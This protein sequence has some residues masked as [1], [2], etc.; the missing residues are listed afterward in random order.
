MRSPARSKRWTRGR[1]ARAPECVR[2]CGLR[3]SMTMPIATRGDMQGAGF[4]LRNC[5]SLA[6]R[7]ACGE[8]QLATNFCRCASALTDW[9]WATSGLRRDQARQARSRCVGPHGRGRENRSRGLGPESENSSRPTRQARAAGPAGAR[10]QDAEDARRAPHGLSSPSIFA[11]FPLS[12]A[13][14]AEGARPLLSTPK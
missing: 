12:S 13:M 1:K 10:L 8:A 5:T 3:D 14:R 2:R 6:I 11:P 9:N 7:G 4:D